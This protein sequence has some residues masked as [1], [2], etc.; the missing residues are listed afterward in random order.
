MKTGTINAILFALLFSTAMACGGEAAK[1][2]IANFDDQ[3][4]IAKIEYEKA[5]V[6]LTIGPRTVT[7]TN[8]V[9]KYTVIQGQYPSFVFNPPKSIPKDWS[10]YEAFSF[11]VWSPNDTGIAIRIDDEKSF[12]YNSRYNGGVNVQKGRTLVQIPI[13]NIA[14]SIDVSKI[15]TLILFIADPP[16]GLTLHFDDF[17]L[18]PLQADKVDFIPYNERYDLTSS[19]EVV[20]PHLPLARNLAGGPV[21]VF[22]LASVKFGREVVEM[23]QRMDLKVSQLTWDREWGANTW[24]FGDFYGLRGHSIDYVLMQKYL[25]SSMQGPE[26]FGALVMYTPLGWSSFTLSARKA[27]IKRVKE[28]GEGLVF[29]MPFP[30]GPQQNAPWPDDLKEICALVDSKT[31]WIR[32]G[33]DVRYANDGRIIGKKW[34][35]TKDHPITAGVPLESLPFTHME[36]Q[37]YAPAPD[38]E[39]LIA[40][41][42]G[43]P[44]LAIRQCG[45]GRVVTFATR[46]LSLTPIMTPPEEFQNK[47]PY[48]FWE[49]WYNLENRAIHWAAGREF[50]RAGDPV[51]LKPTQEQADSYFAARQWKDAQGKVT[52]W[53]L[54]FT[55]PKTEP[56]AFALT[57]PTAIKPGDAIKVSFTP[58]AGT[59]GAEWSAILGEIGNS[60][61]RTLETVAKVENNSVE[62]PSNRVRQYM[63]YVKIEGRKEGN[64][65]ALGKGEVIVTPEP[66]WDDYEI[67]T[68]LESGLPFLQDF[69]QQRM[70]DFGLTCN[71]TSPWDINECK[72]LFRA[73]MRVH[74]CGCTQGLHPKDLD[75]QSKKYKETKDKAC[76]IRNP[77]YADAAF[78]A[79]EREQIQKYVDGL[80]DFA[81]LS[82]IMSDETALTS[83]TFEFD[84]DFHPANV[85]KFREKMKSKFETIDALNAA[86]ATTFK[87][88]DEVQPPVSEDAKAAKNFGLWNEWRAFND[89]MWAGAFKMYGD[90]MKEKAPGSRVSVSG[91][92]ESAI[93]NGIDW[94]KMTPNFGAVCGYGGRFQELQRLCFH[95]NDLRV[96]PWGG[97]GRSGRA[98]DHQLWSSLTT[99]GSGMGLFWWISLRNADLTFCKSGKDYQRVFAEIKAGI[100]KQYMQSKRH[101]SPVGILW[102]ASSQRA[103]W[104]LGKFDEFKKIEAE[105]VNGLTSSE[106]DPFFISEES[107]V[108]GELSER[109]AKA[110]V[111]PMSIS[112]GMGAK[113]GGLAVVPALEKFIAGGGTVIVTD[114]VAFDEFLQ[115]AKLPETL[116]GKIVKFADIKGDIAAGLAKAS[117]KPWLRCSG[118][119]GARIKGVS[120]TVH[121]IPGDAGGFLVTI[122]R[123]PIGA[124]DVVG[125]DGVIHSVPDTE[126]GKEIETVTI[127]VSQ[128]GATNFYD[129]RKNASLKVADGKLTIEL[130]AGDGYPIAALPYSVESISA[131]AAKKD[132]ALNVSWELKGSAKSFAAHVVRI[133]F[134]DAAT[135]KPDP[136]F[137]ANVNC[138]ADGKGS[139]SFPLATEDESRPVLVRVHDVLSG[140]TTE[141]K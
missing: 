100:G 75:G 78:L 115:P 82:M 30:G 72:R 91:T 10:K 94:A 89:D 46:A 69:E 133:E 7:E 31:D 18:G 118:P 135:G 6:E 125:A 52:D 136:N 11:L 56:K 126:G 96:T 92:Q 74:G 103:S 21:P 83:Y 140:K 99:G 14:K 5:N 13:S 77:S 42:S 1:F 35:K 98:V 104:T 37:K 129:I 26:K 4:D 44:V 27:L 15:K 20:S 120:S 88:F 132:R 12:N 119:T 54:N 128:L 2:V 24:G 105:V 43:E 29:V 68:W 53:E 84:Y 86:L 113:K 81:P 3:A 102:S 60:H 49:T 55:P 17:Q 70:L 25:D 106:F 8:N 58:P 110:I 85:A 73:G 107:V 45:K 117:V 39:V 80:K 101:F 87:S 141:A 47:I 50:K 116:S 139:F 40:T 76:L 108:G 112:L 95:P 134:L 111:L 61:W 122:L 59:E 138:G 62:L 114:D 64:L 137:H 33:C 79:K 109:G 22:M 63:A 131:T 32:D 123:A 90:A 97:Y 93:F 48:R 9:L 67:H 66:K 36:V 19:L 127:D 16:K 34:A 28:D 23:M 57:L 130:Q 38:A 121:K 51:E 65:I 71:T 124:K 41:E